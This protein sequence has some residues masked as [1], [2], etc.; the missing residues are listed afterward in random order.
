MENLSKNIFQNSCDRKPLDTLCSP[1]SIDLTW[2]SAPQILCIVLKKHRIELPSKAIDVKV[3]QIVIR[4]FVNQGSQITESDFHGSDKSHIFQSFH[5]E[6]D[7][8]IIEL[9]IKQDAGHPMSGQH[10]PI[11]FLRIRAV[12]LKRNFSV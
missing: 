9:I 4:L 5:L 11:F 3:L 2:M 8:I 1:G 12:L 10:D 6:R 7:R